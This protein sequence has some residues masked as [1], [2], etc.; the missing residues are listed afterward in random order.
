MKYSEIEYCYECSGNMNIGN[1]IKQI[2]FPSFDYWNG[3]NKRDAFILMLTLLQERNVKRK[4]SIK[5]LFPHIRGF[6]TP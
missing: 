6:V 4:I 2:S 1:D 3:K 5:G